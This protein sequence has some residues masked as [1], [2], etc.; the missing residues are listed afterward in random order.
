MIT[1][2]ILAAA[3]I[4]FAQPRFD[5]NEVNGHEGKRFSRQQGYCDQQCPPQQGFQQQFDRREGFGQPGMNK[6][7]AAMIAA[8][9]RHGGFYGPQARGMMQQNAPY[10]F[11]GQ[12][13]APQ[14]YGMGGMEGRR[15]AYPNAEKFNRGPQSRGFGQ[16]F[17]GRGQMPC[18]QAPYA[19]RGREGFNGP[20]CDDMQNRRF[21]YPNA[22]KFN[23]QERGNFE[24]REPRFRDGNCPMDDEGCPE[25]GNFEGKGRQFRG[26][27]N[28]HDGNF[29]G[30]GHQFRGENC[31]IDDGG[32]PE[33]GKFEGKGRHG[34]FEGQ[35]EQ[36]DC[37]KD[38]IDATKPAKAPKDIKEKKDADKQAAPQKPEVTELKVQLRNALIEKDYK[39]A[40]KI[41]DRL[42]DI[43]K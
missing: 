11:R 15:F 23:R 5:W 29:E 37:P 38:A 43:D 9:R 10:A 34:N 19:F 6:R 26:E 35:R 1:I 18:P 4:T 8:A 20:Q 42:E 40:G 24:D 22:E 2:T 21:A 16:D 39:A 14:Q 31:P 32:C 41:L 17:Q 30:K 12:G 7:K 36:G 25:Q 33:Q 13:F 28:G 27:G 3:A